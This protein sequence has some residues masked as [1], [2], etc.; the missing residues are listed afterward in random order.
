MNKQER[1]LVDAKNAVIVAEAA[2]QERID[3]RAT[4]GVEGFYIYDR[5]NGNMITHKIK[6]ND[7]RALFG[8]EWKDMT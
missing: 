2:F 3:Y 7:H 4:N 5:R 8:Y 1:A 6:M